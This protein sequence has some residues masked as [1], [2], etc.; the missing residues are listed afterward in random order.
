VEACVLVARNLFCVLRQIPARVAFIVATLACIF[1]LPAAWADNAGEQVT[2][3]PL[4]LESERGSE[5]FTWFHLAP[6][7]TPI[8]VDGSQAWHSFRPTGSAF[9]A[10]V[11]VDVLSE[12]DGKIEGASLGL[13]RSFIDDPRNGVF[14]RDIAKSFM[15]WAVRKP[16]PAVSILIA[17]IDDLSSAYHGHHARAGSRATA[18][19]YNRRISHLSRSRAAREL[20]GQWRDA[21][22]HEFSRQVASRAHV[23]GRWRP[24]IE[25]RLRMAQNRRSL[26]GQ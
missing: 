3:M 18:A 11:E 23:R 2:S 24:G 5:F 10:L 22:F 21:R 14:A 17:N 9:Q 13:D 15:A 7:G 12:A 16:S 6:V 4:N 20:R 26:L 25:A 19:R 1:A 8:A